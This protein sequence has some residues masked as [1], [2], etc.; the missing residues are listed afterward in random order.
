MDNIIKQC[1]FFLDFEKEIAETKTIT[2]C[3]ELEKITI[4]E[5]LQTN[6]EYIR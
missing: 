1:H 5:K 4:S 3:L 2:N 6:P